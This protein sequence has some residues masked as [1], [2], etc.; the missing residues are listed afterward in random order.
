MLSENGPIGM[1]EA[2]EKARCERE[3]SQMRTHLNEEPLMRANAQFL[4]QMRG[5]QMD[6][7]P[8]TE[9]FCVGIGMFW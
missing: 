6:T 8:F 3:D 2:Q 7:V 4:E 5:M 9:N 1:R